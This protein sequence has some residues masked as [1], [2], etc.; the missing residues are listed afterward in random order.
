MRGASLAAES[1]AGITL[2]ETSAGR[3]SPSA[4]SLFAN[5]ATKSFLFGVCTRCCTGSTKS[6][7][8]LSQAVGT[9]VKWS[10]PG[11]KR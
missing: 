8:G 4:A 2:E 7:D 11:S 10:V 5:R 1:C 6:M 9:R 3:K